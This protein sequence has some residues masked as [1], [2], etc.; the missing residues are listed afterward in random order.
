MFEEHVKPINTLR[1]AEF[2]EAKARE[3]ERE[4]ML[5]NQENNFSFNSFDSYENIKC[6]ELS[7]REIRPDEVPPLALTNLPD[8][9]S[10]SDEEEDEMKQQM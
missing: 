9:V 3:V 8:Y 1:F 2:L 10:T 6:N 4:E 5:D 7:R